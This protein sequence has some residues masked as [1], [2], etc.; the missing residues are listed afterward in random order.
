[1]KAT[2]QLHCSCCGTAINPGDEFRIRNGEFF[3]QEHD[4][5]VVSIPCVASMDAYLETD[6]GYLKKICPKIK[7]EYQKTEQLNLFA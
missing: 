2:K 4:P 7:L 3:K 5:G 6:P 1:M